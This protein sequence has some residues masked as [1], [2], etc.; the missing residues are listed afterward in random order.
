MVNTDRAIG[1]RE[2]SS[3]PGVRLYAPT[4]DRES[5]LQREPWKGWRVV[6]FPLGG[7]APGQSNEHA[8]FVHAYFAQTAMIG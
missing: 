4:G 3:I 2:W 5:R 6:A 8:P 7:S 1:N